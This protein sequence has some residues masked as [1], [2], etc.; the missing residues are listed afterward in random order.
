MA[1]GYTTEEVP[2]Y[3]GGT[4]QEVAHDIIIHLQG[5]ELY[6]GQFLN[7]RIP[8]GRGHSCPTRSPHEREH[9]N[10][11]LLQTKPQLVSGGR[12]SH[13]AHT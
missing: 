3:R 12:D 4:N 7:V 6:K 5:A 8:R 2:T 1:A 13:S 9:R 10:P 11:E